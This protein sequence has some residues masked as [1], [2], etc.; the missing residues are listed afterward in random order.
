MKVFDCGLKEN[1]KAFKKFVE[2]H[3]SRSSLE[4]YYFV[5]EEDDCGDEA[6]VFTTQGDLDEWLEKTFWDRE[7]YETSNLEDSMYDFHVWKLISESDFKR[8][9]ALY[10]GAK[11]TSIVIKGEKYFRKKISV[12]VEQTVTV[13]TNFY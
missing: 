11:L 1:W 6:V 5:F 9:D 8:L 2:S 13:S 12:D 10:K 7:R 4:T 3:E